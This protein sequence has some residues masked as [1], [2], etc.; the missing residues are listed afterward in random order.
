MARSKTLAAL[1]GELTTAAKKT[2]CRSVINRAAIY[3]AACERRRTLA[4]LDSL[5]DNDSPDLV[6]LRAMIVAEGVLE[7]ITEE[8]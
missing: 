3:G 1:D 8:T 4:L 6:R 2:Q 7:T 5:V